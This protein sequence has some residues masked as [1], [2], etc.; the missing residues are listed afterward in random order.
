M[1]RKT[2]DS[3]RKQPL[4]GRTNI[5][6]SR[7]GS[8]EPKG[9]VV[10]ERFEEAVDIGRE[11]LAM[12]EELGEEELVAATLNNIGTARA[13]AGDA[14]GIHD[15]ERSIE[16]A[17]RIASPESIRGH[18]NLAAISAFFGD[19]RRSAELHDRAMEQARRFGR[20]RYIRFLMGEA[21]TD[22]LAF[23]DWDEA[24]RAAD[25]VV[26]EVEAGAALYMESACR[27]IRATMALARDDVGPALAEMSRALERG[28]QLGEPQS[29]LPALGIVAWGRADAD[30]PAEARGLVDELLANAA[31]VPVALWGFP[32]AIAAE[33][34]GRTSELLAVLDA[35]DETPWGVAT[36]HY[37]HGRYGE[38]A[39]TL[40]A[41]GDLHMA[42]HARLRAAEALGA[43]GRKVE[44]DAELARAVDF[45]RS[46]RATRYL[47]RAEG[48][49]AAAS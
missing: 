3:L 10:C 22:A 14:A 38:A 11:A 42:A 39:D 41:I 5:V 28:R 34:V 4:P 7:D 37:A 20:T 45:F 33:R 9:A 25:A 1:G 18:I 19:L 47:R 43:A 6:L 29:L 44:A 36:R 2:W 17:T 30:R 15:L 12:A 23:G 21:A 31:G 40:E 27:V 49:L 13:N 46:V 24:A 16:I 8:F 32:G 26:A 48:L 35:S